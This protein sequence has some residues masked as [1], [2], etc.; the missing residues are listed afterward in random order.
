MQPIPRITTKTVLPRTQKLLSAR[1]SI[2]AGYTL[3]EPQE[4]GQTK[5][6]NTEADICIFGG[7]AGAGKSQALLLK[8]AK[9]I[10]VPGYGSVIFRITS[11]EITNEGGLW[12][13]S[14]KL[15]SNIKGANDREHWLDWSFPKGSS[16]SFGHADKLQKKYLG[17]SMCH[18]GIDELVNWSEADFFFLLSRNRSMCGVTPRI[19]AT[20]NPDADSW[21]AQLIEWWIDPDTGFAIEERSGVLRYFYRIN[22]KLYWAD[23]AAELE[24]Q[25]PDM[26]VIA[27]PKSLTFIRGT[28]YENKALLNANPQ[29]L[30]SLLALHPVEMERLLKGNWKV[31][32]EAGKVFNRAWF[33]IIE[34]DAV[35]Q[36]HYDGISDLPYYRDRVRFWDMAAT[37]KELNK[38]ACYTCGILMEKLTSYEGVTTY[39]IWDMQAEQLSPSEGD[40]LIIQQAAIDGDDV[41][42]RW[43]LEGGSSGLKVESYLIDKLSGY[44]AAGVRP[45]GD[46]LTRAKPFATEAKNGRVKLI[47]GEWNNAFLKWYHAFDGTNGK[48]KVNDP[49]DAGSGAYECLQEADAGWVRDV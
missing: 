6:Y 37:A 46:K 41:T 4:G 24:E 39:I 15:Y 10:D 3:P 31:K 48:D 14:K 42:V 38:D 12:D 5:F 7:A 26:A 11:P 35:A 28:I 2:E 49:I 45:R 1:R 33:E 44:D 36:Y 21:V 9:H 17:A 20:C 8:A 30:A 22:E 13:E 23:T 27:P 43:E 18:I 19:D 34:A 25:F 16:I 47:R 40:A 32:Y 29:Y